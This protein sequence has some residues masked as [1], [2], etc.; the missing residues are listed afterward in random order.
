MSRTATGRDETWPTDEALLRQCGDGETSALDILFHRYE[1]AV[2]ALLYRVLDDPEQAAEALTEVF[3]KVWRHARQWRGEAQVATWIYRIT[4]RTALDTARRRRREMP[5]ESLDAGDRHASSGEDP[6]ARVVA[7]DERARGAR[8]V[9]R[10]LAALTAPDRL[11]L[12]LYYLEEHSY[13][14]IQQITGL[15]YPVL[16]MRLSRARRRLR[17]I[18]TRL[19]NLPDGFLS[20]DPGPPPGM[21]TG[22]L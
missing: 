22:P 16:K 9:E 21:A 17:T 5:L 12:V 11:L 19:E 6:S 20:S 18:L 8:L 15:A 14:E 4:A 1:R 13:A 10:G 7:A 2:Y 3:L